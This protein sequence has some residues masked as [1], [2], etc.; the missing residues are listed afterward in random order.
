ME[1]FIV[2]YNIFLVLN[3]LADFFRKG[4][5]FGFWFV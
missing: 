3:V 2:A 1:I 5:R 4:E